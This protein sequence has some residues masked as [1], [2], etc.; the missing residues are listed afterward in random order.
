MRPPTKLHLPIFNQKNVTTLYYPLYYPNLSPPN[1]FLFS[2]LKTKLKGLHFADVAEIQ[3][4]I[5]DESKKFPKKGNLGSFL[6]TV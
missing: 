3:E 6:E 5:T 4:A 2:K 1:N